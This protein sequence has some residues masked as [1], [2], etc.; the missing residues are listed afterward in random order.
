MAKTETKTKPKADTKLSA[1]NARLK[2]QITRMRKEA[3]AAKLKQS[4]L[5]APILK[6]APIAK[7]ARRKAPI[8]KVYKVRFSGKVDPEDDDEVFLS[9]NGMS[10]VVGRNVTVPLPARYLEVAQNA[11]TRSFIFAPDGTVV[12]TDLIARYPFS[13]LGESN[14]TEFKKY[15]A[16]ARQAVVDAAKK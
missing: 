10:L 11:T 4:S 5:A 13:I 12:H 7:K 6:P 8:E 3:E 1:E 16:D 15:I 9:V 14:F 2:A